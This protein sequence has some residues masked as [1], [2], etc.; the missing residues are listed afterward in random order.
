MLNDRLRHSQASVAESG[1]QK[2]GP[3]TGPL[4]SRLVSV[5]NNGPTITLNISMAI[6]LFNN[7]SLVAIPMIAITSDVTIMIPVTISMVLSHSYA[8]RANTNPDFFRTSRHCAANSSYGSDHYDVLNHC[9]FL[10]LLDFRRAML[11]HRHRSN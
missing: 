4:G 8:N 10:S 7:N 5:D 3:I 1:R 2:G 6:A 11:R 9:V